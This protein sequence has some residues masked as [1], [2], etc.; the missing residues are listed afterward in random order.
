MPGWDMADIAP[1]HLFLRQSLLPVLVSAVVMVMMDN[2]T[3]SVM[4]QF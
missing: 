1:N 3:P 4:P 2:G